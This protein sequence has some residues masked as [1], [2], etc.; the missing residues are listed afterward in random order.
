MISDSYSS[1]HMGAVIA[2]H[3]FYEGHREDANPNHMNSAARR[4][5]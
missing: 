5:E 4:A 3:Q 1:T 2:A